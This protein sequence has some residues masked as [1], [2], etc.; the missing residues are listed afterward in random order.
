MRALVTAPAARPRFGLTLIEIMVS[1]TVTSVLIAAAVPFFVA[2]ARAVGATAARTDMHHNA[3]YAVNTID[4]DL[5]VA[6][7]G[8]V[9]AQP[10][11]VY[12]GPRYV[13][14]NADLVS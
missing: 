11:I 7:V 12:A 6:G 10:M 9:G 13:T 3:R 4:R 2:Q 8:V 14:V 1:M 5:R